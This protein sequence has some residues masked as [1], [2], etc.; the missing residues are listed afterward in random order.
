[1]SKLEKMGVPFFHL[2]TNVAFANYRVLKGGGVQG[3]GVFLV[4][5]EDSY[6]RLGNLR[7]ITNP[8][9]KAVQP[10]N[11]SSPVPGLNLQVAASFELP[12]PPRPTTRE[13]HFPQ[14]FEGGGYSS[15]PHITK[16]HHLKK[17]T[18]ILPK[19]MRFQSN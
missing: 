19:D 3:E 17:H 16:M 7:G 8:I 13:I 10:V 1:M 15:L 11:P 18:H 6:K 4:N 5:P 9:S 2:H 12:C 14:L